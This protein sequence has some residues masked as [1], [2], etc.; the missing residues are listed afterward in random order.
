MP[1]HG[2]VPPGHAWRAGARR[3][4]RLRRRAL[5]LRRQAV[6]AQPPT[7]FRQQAVQL[8]PRPLCVRR[9]YHLPQPRGLSPANPIPPHLPGRQWLCHLPRLRRLPRPRHLYRRLYR[10]LCRRRSAPRPRPCAPR[11][12]RPRAKRLERAGCCPEPCPC[13]RGRGR[14]ASADWGPCAYD[15]GSGRASSPHGRTCCRHA[16][17]SRTKWAG[18]HRLRPRLRRRHSRRRLVAPSS[19]WD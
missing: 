4:P 18:G 3:L 15:R 9:G 19:S 2:G 12:G 16:R 14:H 5:A 13:R 11:L 6:G 8:Q 1:H 7:A 17:H 10:R